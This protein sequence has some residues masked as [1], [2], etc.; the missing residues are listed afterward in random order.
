MLKRALVLMVKRLCYSTTSQATSYIETWNV[1]MNWRWWHQ[2]QTPRRW[3]LGRSQC[4]AST[5][6]LCVSKSGW[7]YSPE[8]GEQ[9]VLL[10]PC[11]FTIT[12][13]QLSNLDNV[14]IKQ[15]GPWK[16]KPSILDG[17]SF[18]SAGEGRCNEG[19]GCRYFEPGILWGTATKSWGLHYHLI[20]YWQ[21]TGPVPWTC[22]FAWGSQY[23]ITGRRVCSQI[24][25]QQWE[26]LCFSCARR[27][28]CCLCA[29]RSWSVATTYDWQQRT[30]FFCFLDFTLQFLKIERCTVISMETAQWETEW[31]NGETLKE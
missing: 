15:R 5:D 14:V 19:A 20:S 9:S 29:E 28:F 27:Y 30:P 31:I 16:C 6:T 22:C 17:Q 8:G 3:G 4:S 11:N 26:H 12:A 18:C 23:G 7:Q 13:S 1:R 10:W 21:E 2:L 25:P 24:S